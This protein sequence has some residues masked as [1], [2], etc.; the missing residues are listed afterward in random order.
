MAF[1][2]DIRAEKNSDNFQLPALELQSY[3]ALEHQYMSL[4]AVNEVLISSRR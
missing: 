1:L 4:R 2:G 3:K